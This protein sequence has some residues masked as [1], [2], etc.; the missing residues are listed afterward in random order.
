M[1]VLE[2]PAPVPD[3]SLRYDARASAVVDVFEPPGAANSAVI[4]LHGGFWRAAYDRVHLRILAAALASGGALVA[5]PE[6]RRVGEPGGGV[7]GTI[8]DTRQILQRVPAL[9]GAEPAD[10]I[11]GGHSAGGHLALVAAST[12][13]RAPRRVVS[14]AGVV[15]LAAGH[16]DG[17]SRGAVAELLGT[18]S[19]SPEG[20]AAIDPLALALPRCEIV[21]IH[22]ARDDQ[23]PVSYSEAYAARDPRIRLEVRADADHYDLIDPESAAYPGVSAA[24]V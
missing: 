24:F 8:D 20:I 15:D 11:V 10:V 19:P 17:L 1:H 21:L 14:L 12:A 5:L 13:P 3:R 18:A 7:P 23:V 2:R 6:Y 22:G 4:L 9:L 16:A